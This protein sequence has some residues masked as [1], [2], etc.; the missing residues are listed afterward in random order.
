MDVRLRGAALHG[1]LLHGGG[2]RGQAERR[3]EPDRRARFLLPH[4]LVF[5][6]LWRIVLRVIINFVFQDADVLRSDLRRSPVC[7]EERIPQ[8]IISG[9]GFLL[10]QHFFLLHK[11][12]S[13]ESKTFF[14][15]SRTS[16]MLMLHETIGASWDLVTMPMPVTR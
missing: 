1:R 14:V 9:L 15:I 2:G 4:I 5:I 3:D 8:V 7:V 13:H 12:L 6:S 11:I 16:V 10:C